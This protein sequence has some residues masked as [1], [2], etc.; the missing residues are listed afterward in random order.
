MADGMGALTRGLPY[1]KFRPFETRKF[2]KC[3]YCQFIF[4]KKDFL[5]PKFSVQRQ[6][7]NLVEIRLR[8]NR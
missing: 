2:E 4:S 8:V 7:E 5:F 3:K 1:R 6:R